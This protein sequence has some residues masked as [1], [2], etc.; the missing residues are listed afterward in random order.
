MYN[1]LNRTTYMGKRSNKEEFIEKAKQIHGNK[2]DYSKVNYINAHTKVCIICQEHGEFWQTPNKHLSGC[3]CQSCAGKNKNKEYFI[4][5]SREIHG[6]KYNYSKVD[7]INWNTKVCII[8]PKH[9]EFWQSPLKHINEKHNCPKCSKRVKLT[10]EEF[11][12]RAKIAHGNKYDYSKVEYINS[13]TK[14]CII[15]PKHGEFWQSPSL[16]L[17]GKGCSKCN[18]GVK[19]SKNDFIERAKIAHGNKYDYSK[20]KYI[21][22]RTKVCVIC[23]KHGEFFV[24]PD[25]HMS[26]VGC[27]RCMKSKCETEVEKI[28]IKNNIK[29]ET[30]KEFDWL[31]NKR[32]LKLDFYLPE[33]NV[34]IECQGIQHFTAVK[35]FG[36]DKVFKQTIDRDKIKKVLCEKHNIKIIYFSLF[37]N[38]N[39]INNFTKLLNEITSYDSTI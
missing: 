19:I 21:N 30:Q 18:G 12:E 22:A 15:C 17:L 20:V 36:G 29:Y 31:A 14:V 10:T 13:H 8:C 32:N 35:H 34:A 6:D 37:R 3:G 33:Y 28:L 4:R 16:H 7:Y 11:V 26:G 39:T 5:K 1:E 25:H 9:G 27:S 23:P 38:D 24:R 2:Y